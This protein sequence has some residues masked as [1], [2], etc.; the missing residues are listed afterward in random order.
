MLHR[1]ERSGPTDHEELLA[2]GLLHG[3]QHADALVVVVVPHRV[4]LRVAG[5]QV[6]G[7][8]LAG[9]DGEPG[10]DA[11][12]DLEAEQRQAVP[13][14]PRPVLGERKLVDAGD[15]GDDGVGVAPELVADVLA[16][17]DAHA[18]VVAL[19]EHPVGQRVAEL[20]V[21]VDHRD[22]GVHGLAPGRRHLRTVVRQQHD[23]VGL[24]R[25]ERL[26]RGPLLGDVLAG[27]DRDER[28]LAV[29]LRL[30]AGVGRDGRDPAVVGGRRREAD[31]DGLAR[32][33]VVALVVVDG[34]VVGL[35][36]V[37][38]PVQAVSSTPA[39][40]ADPTASSRRRDRAPEV[41]LMRTPGE[42][43]WGVLYPA[44]VHIRRTPCAWIGTCRAGV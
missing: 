36:S 27:G 9:G 2:A 16:G 26:D 24:L 15:L 18:V 37:S 4:D 41:S 8:L 12:P 19:D 40:T 42:V 34:L 13:E 38:L 33:G 14:A 7:D 43:E 25:D 30:R 3:L 21:Q 22:A 10:R 39:P 17:G 28:H 35:S 5:Q 44:F 31:L 23:D 32:R 11:G 6:G 20:A 29:L 1:V